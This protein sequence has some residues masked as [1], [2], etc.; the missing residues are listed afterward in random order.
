MAK[1]DLFEKLKSI[2]HRSSAEENSSEARTGEEI[3]DNSDKITDEPLTTYH[4]TLYS[5]DSSEF[6]KQ[7][8]VHTPARPLFRDM[9]G[10]EKNIDSLSSHRLKSSGSAI[11][12][13][14][15]S[16]LSGKKSA[17][18]R[19]IANVIYVVSK[20]QPGQVKGDWAVRSHQKIYSHHRTKKAAI[21]AARKVALSRD[22]TVLVQN[23]DGTF[24]SGFKPRKKKP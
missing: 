9:N 13:K 15:D 16:I 7:S 18:P 11:G 6:K 5:S 8:S 10:I 19:R 2:L 12:K 3:R 20:P 4:E 23:T 21:N 22:A 14:V 17:I 24:S 1:K